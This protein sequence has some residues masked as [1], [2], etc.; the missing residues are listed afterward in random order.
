MI[1]A[2]TALAGPAVL[3]ITPVALQRPEAPSVL[4]WREPWTEGAL[5]SVRVDPATLVRT[6]LPSPAW[7]V[8]DQPVIALGADPVAGCAV[9][10]VEGPVDWSAAPVFLGPAE[11]TE[12]LDAATAAARVREAV[13]AGAKPLPADAVTAATEATVRLPH[14]GGLRPL[15][16]A[17][18]AACRA[19]TP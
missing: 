3:A 5:L 4:P 15:A 6:A 10:V 13:A 16:E 12:R 9:F 7:W 17:H 1:L 14:S 8:G 18:L 11:L 2:A 19:A